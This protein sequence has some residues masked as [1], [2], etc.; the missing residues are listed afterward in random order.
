MAAAG[1]TVTGERAMIGGRGE[2]VAAY[3]HGR[4]PSEE[5]RTGGRAR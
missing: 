5:A 1:T 3:R 2:K 4:R